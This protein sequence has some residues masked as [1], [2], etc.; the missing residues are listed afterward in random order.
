MRSKPSSAAS[1]CEASTKWRA[2]FDAV[3]A[4]PRLGLE[5]QVIQDE[6]QVGLAR[7]V[8]GQGDGVVVGAELFQRGAMNW[9]R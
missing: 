3:D 5:K 7:A 8:V 9:Y 1:F 6:A 2:G 4:A